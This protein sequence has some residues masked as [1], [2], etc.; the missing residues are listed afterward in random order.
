MRKTPICVGGVRIELP[1][2]GAGGIAVPALD[3]RLGPRLGRAVRA[4]AGP[5]TRLPLFPRRVPGRAAGG[6]HQPRAWRPGRLRVADGAA[7][8][9]AG[10][11]GAAGP[12]VVSRDLLPRAAGRGAAGADRRR[13]LAATPPGGAVGQCLWHPHRVG[14]AEAAGDLHDA[15]RRRA[16]GLCR[17]AF[18]RPA[19]GLAG[20]R[21]CRCPSSRSRTSAPAWPARC[22]CW[23]RGA[24]RGGWPTRIAWPWR[25]LPPASC[26]RCSR[27]STTRRPSCWR[28]CWWR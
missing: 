1:S 11:Q 13:D 14:R 28:R 23:R 4:G 19:P 26:C 20:Q 5:A 3:A 12:G 8:G 24:W 16:A 10:R 25:R 27:D 6:A 18:G 15:G 17:I 21:A 9:S 7:A 22:C 2:M